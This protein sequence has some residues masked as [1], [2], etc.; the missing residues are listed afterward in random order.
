[1]NSSVYTACLTFLV[2]MHFLDIHQHEK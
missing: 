1:M 2:M